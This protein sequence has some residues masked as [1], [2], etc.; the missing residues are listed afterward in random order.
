[1]DRGLICEAPLGEAIYQHG[2]PDEGLKDRAASSPDKGYSRRIQY[3]QI[4]KGN[5]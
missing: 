2:H 4:F 5:P 3:S 1:M